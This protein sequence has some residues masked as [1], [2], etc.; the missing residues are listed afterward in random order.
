MHLDEDA[1]NCSTDP[2]EDGFQLASEEAASYLFQVGT[3]QGECNG[4]LSDDG[5]QCCPKCFKESFLR[6][7]EEHGLVK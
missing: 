1:V 6:N 2:T 5:M 4:H 3:T 7:T